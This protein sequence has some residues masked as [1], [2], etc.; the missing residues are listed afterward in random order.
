MKKYIMIVAVLVATSAQV[1][2]YTYPPAVTAGMRRTF[3]NGGLKPATAGCIIA[4]VQEQFSFDEFT[5]SMS[6]VGEGAE[7]SPAM[8]RIAMM[9]AIET[10]D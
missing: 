7:L 1:F 8:K 9:C 6:S 5:E 2:A 3:V 10:A 4:K